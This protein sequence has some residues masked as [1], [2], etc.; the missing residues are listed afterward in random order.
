ME[1]WYVC[2]NV[3][4]P[5]EN[6]IQQQWLV[7]GPMTKEKAFEKANILARYKEPTEHYT[8]IEMKLA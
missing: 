1:N 5:F 8:I 3:I 4:K 7:D 2:I 6:P